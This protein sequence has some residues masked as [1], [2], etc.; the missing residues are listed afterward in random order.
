M[1]K[2]ALHRIVFGLPAE[3]VNRGN[4][5]PLEGALPAKVGNSSLLAEA[6][7]PSRVAFFHRFLGKSGKTR[8]FCKPFKNREF[9][10]APRAP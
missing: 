1:E 10:T 7:S 2:S 9:D 6:S 5:A 4:E 3:Q 8:Y